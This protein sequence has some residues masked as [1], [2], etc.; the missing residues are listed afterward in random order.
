[1]YDESVFKIKFVKYITQYP[2]LYDFTQNDH[3]KRNETK[4]ACFN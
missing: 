1:M 2:Y 4:K 3:S